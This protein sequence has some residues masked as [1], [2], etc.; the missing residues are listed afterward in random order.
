M[1]FVAR[2]SSPDELKNAAVF[3]T[4][5]FKIMGALTLRTVLHQTLLM[6]IL[7]VLITGFADLSAVALCITRLV[8][9]EA[10]IGFAAG[11]TFLYT[12]ASASSSV[13]LMLAT[14]DVRAKKSSSG[15][16]DDYSNQSLKD[17]IA[18]VRQQTEKNAGN[19]RAFERD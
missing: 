7:P 17:K 19:D 12:V 18:L 4:K 8:S 15:D 1:Q 11:L 5:P 13:S 3:T 6:L 10:A 9:L 2:M 16:D 14:R